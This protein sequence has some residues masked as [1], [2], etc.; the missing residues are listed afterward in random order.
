MTILA[1]VVGTGNREWPRGE[2]WRID[3]RG[4]F[5]QVTTWLDRAWHWLCD[6]C[7]NRT[8]VRTARIFNEIYGQWGPALTQYLRTATNE[9]PDQSVNRVMQGLK[10]LQYYVSTKDPLFLERMKGVDEA[11]RT[12]W[13]QFIR[14]YPNASRN[15]DGGDLQAYQQERELLLQTVRDLTNEQER[16]FRVQNGGFQANQQDQ[17]NQQEMACLLQTV[18]DLT[19]EREHML[20]EHSAL[21]EQL[22]TCLRNE[23]LRNKQGQE[24]DDSLIADATKPLKERIE[25]LLQE[26]QKLADAQQIQKLADAQQIQKLAD[27]QQI[28]KLA[29]DQLHLD[30]DALRAKRLQQF[31]TTNK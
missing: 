21:V 20:Q 6:V 16:L 23:Q 27:A 2:D 3:D 22:K 15:V 28:Q 14:L 1:N 17:A 10:T 5:Y 25:H 24:Y 12:N 8:A 11:F 30:P 29:D 13:E 9:A 4:E 31:D 26:N 18:S 19:D 7:T